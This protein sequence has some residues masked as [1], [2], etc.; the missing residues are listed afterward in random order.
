MMQKDRYIAFVCTGNT[1]R[2]PMAEGIF[3]KLAE[4]K[5]L[6][7]RAV[8]FGLAAV[9]GMTPS[10][11]A[12]KACAEIGIELSGKKSNFVFDF[13][14]ADFEKI[15]C[16]SDEHYQ[17]LTQSVGLPKDRV[18]VLDIRDPYGSSL[19]VYKLCR[20]MIYT[21]VEEIIRSYET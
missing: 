1:C 21:A 10:E 2:S 6:D 12:I 15:Y 4:E 8:S 13:D 16:M 19:E 7:V 18:E 20:D 5:G 9:K 17:I 3:N 11:K 14:I